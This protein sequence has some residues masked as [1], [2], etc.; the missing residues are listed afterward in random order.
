LIT[1]SSRGLGLALAEAALAAGQKLVATA[2]DPARLADL[3][4]RYPDQIPAFALEVT[5]PRAA[6]GQGGSGQEMAPPESLHQLRCCL[7]TRPLAPTGASHSATGF[8]GDAG[9][10][11]QGS[12]VG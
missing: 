12:Q 5:D 4:D 3:V 2:R 9:R 10:V 11:D 6:G 1:G 8:G 7:V